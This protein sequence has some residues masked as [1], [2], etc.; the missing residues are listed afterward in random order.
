[1]TVKS[2]DPVATKKNAL[3]FPPEL[4]LRAGDYG[5]VHS[6]E[7]IFFKMSHSNYVFHNEILWIYTE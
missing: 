4:N 3:N 6:L 7:G 1:M 5:N 2:P